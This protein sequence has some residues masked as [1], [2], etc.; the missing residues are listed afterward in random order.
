MTK[1]QNKFRTFKCTKCFR[2]KIDF[3]IYDI[4]R[5]VFNHSF[6][7]L[8]NNALKRSKQADSN[9]RGAEPY[10]N[11]RTEDYNLGAI[12]NHSYGTSDRESEDTEANRVDQSGA[13]G[14]INHYHTLEEPD[15]ATP[16]MN[17]R[18]L[19]SDTVHHEP[20]YETPD[21]KRKEDKRPS[22]HSEYDTPEGK[23]PT[24]SMPN[25]EQGVNDDDIKRV[26]VNGDFYTLPDKGDNKV[27]KLYFRLRFVS[28]KSSNMIQQ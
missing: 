1:S 15:Y 2:T 11:I 8:D 14:K 16:D 13:F 20:G 7:L 3:I 22:E 5:L 25:E 21:M 9:L 26:E 17:K 28:D 6:L 19:D 24:Y 4:P 18:K 27:M 23:D 10:Q 12:T